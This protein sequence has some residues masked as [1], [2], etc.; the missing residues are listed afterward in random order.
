MWEY[1]ATVVRWID[2]DTV[3][4][5]LS[6]GF[7]ITTTQRLRLMGSAMGVN[8]PELHATDPATR[9]RAVQAA[10][11]SAALAP[12]G[13][14]FTARTARDKADAFGRFLCEVVL[15]DGRSVGDVLFA[16]GLAVK[17]ERA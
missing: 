17:Y 11:R 8:A 3:D 1:R 5:S 16:E 2:A 10:A 9:A 12:A 13:T 14:A 7:Y 6:L 15:A 4:V